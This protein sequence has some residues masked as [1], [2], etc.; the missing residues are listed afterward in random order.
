MF[1]AGAVLM[2]PEKPG[3]PG[4]CHDSDGYHNIDIWLDAPQK[5]TKPN[6]A[7]PSGTA[8]AE[9]KHTSSAVAWQPVGAV[10]TP[11]AFVA[12][13]EAKPALPMPAALIGAQ[14]L[15]RLIA[16]LPRHAIYDAVA[17]AQQQS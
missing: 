3:E 12:S 15:C 13:A 8:F 1:G 5:A 9:I 14:H 17:P 10:M 4:I 2:Q 7:Q 16:E 11:E 6:D